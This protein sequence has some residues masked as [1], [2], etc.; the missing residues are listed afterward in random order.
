MLS[1]AEE[2]VRLASAD[3]RAA[4]RAAA[5]VVAE[6]VDVEARSVAERALGLAAVELGDV[7]AAVVHLERARELALGGGLAGRAGEADM[8]LAL[9]LTLVGDTAGAL[10][11]LDRAEPAL[12]GHLRAR[13][14]GQRALILQKLG[15]LDEALAGYRRPLR[16]HRASG[17]V[18]WEARLLCNRGVLQVYRGAL[19][20][21][22]SDLAR[23]EE[24]HES[25]GQALAATQVRHNRGWLAARSGDVP[26]ALARY[27]RVEVEYRAHDVPLAL[28]L[29]DRCEVLL[30]A[31]LAAEAKANAAAAV[32]EL[33][34]AGLAADLAEAR[35][36]A[37]HAELLVGDT[38]A[39]REHARRADTAFSRQ[40]RPGWAAL[41]RAAAAEAAWIEA[42]RTDADPATTGDGIGPAGPDGTPRPATSGEVE[43]ATAGGETGSAT[44]GEVETA[45]A[46]GETGSATNGEVETAPAG[47]ATGSATTGEVETATAGGETGSATSGG[48]EPA[49]AGDATGS[50]TSGGNEPATAGDATGSAAS[51][52][53]EP[54]T[55]GDA[56]G[57]AATG[58]MTGSATTGEVRRVRLEAALGAAQRA[59][60]ALE[61][62]GWDVEALDARLIA[63]RAALELGRPRTAR[64]YL[65]LAATGGDRGPVQVRTRASHAAAL[66]R[67]AR[68]DRRG[69]SAAVAAG[70]RAL[71]AHQMTLGAT[72]LR[73][74]ASG[75][76]EA[77]ATLG[78][79]LAVE[80]GSAQRV[81]AAAERR[82]A[83]G[84]MRRPARPPD[85]AALARDLEELRRVSA[86]LEA[87][88]RDGRPET[89]LRRRQAALER[90]VR[91]RALQARGEMRAGTTTA[92]RVGG[93]RVGVSAR[94][95]SDDARG[96]EEAR[97]DERGAGRGGGGGI[98]AAVVRRETASH[99]ALMADLERMPSFDAVVAALGKRVLVEF[100]ALDGVLFT[101]TVV[102]GRAR[103]KRL[104]SEADVAKEVASLRFGLRRLATAAPGSRMAQGMADVVATVA[105]RL[106]ALLALDS[107]AAAGDRP[108]VIVP[109]GEL[110]ALPWSMLPSLDKRPVSVSPSLRLWYRAAFAGPL[111]HRP[112]HVL[113]AGPRLPAA[114]EEIEALA[115]RHPEAT[116]LTHEQATV[117]NVA[118]ALDGADS[119]HVAAHGR[120]RDDNPQF[121]SLELAD[122]NVT[123]YDLERL[124]RLPQRI[125]LSSCE[126]GLSAVHAGDELMG[127]TAAV[128]A[129]GTSTVIAAV[130]PVPDEATK[131]LMLA[132]D[133]ALQAGAKPAE[134]LVKARAKDA[135]MSVAGA[136]FVCFGAG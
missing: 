97:R 29:M 28:L 124:H 91:R 132:L 26:L 58:D 126:S 33:A 99:V 55:A 66:L 75:H 119:A 133:E 15:Q 102:D 98:V 107:T 71:E 42:T 103:L 86:A 111:P 39:A 122:G 40:H 76:G 93:A 54:A 120:F 19:A 45:T 1:V 72:E 73:A 14:Q 127:F 95:D 20:A 70:L 114:T 79:R 116:T 52:G 136:A 22:E 77:L 100:V 112:R 109:T 61:R 10:S 101:V 6:T 57:S 125:V 81:L 24:L 60:R 68:G 13:V 78:L 62:V 4:R 38:A 46:G 35:L 50:A 110:H 113:V 56:T 34:A 12:D 53:N 69:A 135:F 134:A 7:A 118:R 87:G 41:A 59:V 2:A 115:R 129:L 108:L 25:I 74:H 130:V 23:A 51:G 9:A 49:T 63:G 64:R 123:V 92:A 16:A 36:L 31:R 96:G 43:T 30:S 17:D 47:D 44:S 89:E 5:S 37:A 11:A 27:D 104:G 131:G 85:D 21:A 48:N 67:L 8:S 3:A 80:S 90:S 117:A 128:F 105:Q 82:R 106:D 32:T 83:A 94:G 88:L 121:C 84:L 18:L 65:E